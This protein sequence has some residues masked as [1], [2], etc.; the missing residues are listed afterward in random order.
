MSAATCFHEMNRIEAQT[1]LSRRIRYL[2][3]NNRARDNTQKY[4]MPMTWLHAHGRIRK[5]RPGKLQKR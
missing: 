5:S 2:E 1:T 3:G 4:Q